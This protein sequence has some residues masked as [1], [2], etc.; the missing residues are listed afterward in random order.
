VY[1]VNGRFFH[2]HALLCQDFVLVF[3]TALLLHYNYQY[4]RESEREREREREL[5]F[6]Y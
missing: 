1:S 3:I 6:R 2:G 5:L 4:L